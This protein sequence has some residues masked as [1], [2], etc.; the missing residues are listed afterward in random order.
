MRQGKTTTTSEVFRALRFLQGQNLHSL[1]YPRLG[2]DQAQVELSG[3]LELYRALDMMYWL[4][5]VEAML[6]QIGGAGTS[7]RGRD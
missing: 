2:Q 7:T 4:P 6:A 1:C 3:A 5:Q